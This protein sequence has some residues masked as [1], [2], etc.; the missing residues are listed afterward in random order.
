MRFPV[1]I[2]LAF[3]VAGN[4]SC[5]TQSHA[6]DASARAWVAQALKTMGQRHDLHQVAALRAQTISAVWDT[7]E[8][9]HADA[10]FVF[11]GAAQAS[12]IDDLHG[13]R[14]LTD[15]TQLG[16]GAAPS[17]LHTR[18][19]LTPTE[20]RTDRVMAGRP[21]AT[22]RYEAPPAWNTD[23][24]IAVL[25]LAEQASDL[26]RE[27]DV[28]PHGIEQHVVSF[29]RGRYPVRV[30]LDTVTGLPS[31][32]DTTRELRRANSVDIA[33][34]AMGDVV[35]HVELMNYA[36]FDG[37]RYPVQSDLFRNGVHLRTTI[38]NELHMD[39][40]LDAKAFALP[41]TSVTLSHAS[42]DDIA[43]GQAVGLAPDPK[44]PI[45]EIAPGIVQIPGSWFSTIVRQDDGLVIIDAPISTGYSRKVLDEAAQRFP[46]MPVKAL[47]TSTAFYW[48]VA[49][50]REYAARGI[51]IYARD[52]NVSV[53]RAMLNASRTLTPDE[54]ALHP[55]APIIRP[56][57]KA[58][59]IGHGRNAIVLYPVR[60]GEQP[61]Q[62]SWIADAHL[63]HTA[64]MV[65]PLGPNGT[66]IQPESLLE[67]QHS[68][69]ASPIATHGLHMIGM[70]M[71]P[72]AWDVLLQA[73]KD[74]G[75]N[76]VEGIERAGPA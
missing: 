34:N 58:T 56:V 10:P 23:E 43:L 35:D 59:A 41:E 30:F 3:A 53:I 42:V 19:L 67:L 60:E 68:V 15:E 27:A 4:L 7:V 62:M 11:E 38:R 33:Y 20:E 31:A 66:L 50:V 17:S 45:A 64:E 26:M 6:A 44:A 65:M 70:H 75:V 29:H 61:M 72:T 9:D 12:V 18:T 28:S 51:P 55:V 76:G 8:F 16:A 49:G 36:L 39:A 24:P 2:P 52:R 46:G 32:I 57:S 47:I 40:T 74:A 22:T 37:V 71:R 69:E 1:L 14:R 25:L 48:H 21:P 73:L 5:S 63:L 13:G 54:L